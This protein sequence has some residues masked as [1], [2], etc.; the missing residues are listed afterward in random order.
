MK[1]TQNYTRE[2]ALS[3]EHHPTNT[4]PPAGSCTG[5]S[6]CLPPP[7]ACLTQPNTGELEKHKFV[8]PWG[9]QQHHSSA[10]FLKA[11]ARTSSREIWHQDPRAVTWNISWYF[12]KYAP[13]FNANTTSLSKPSGQ[14]SAF[15]FLFT[16][17]LWFA[18]SWTFCFWNETYTTLTWTITL[19]WII[20]IFHTASKRDVGKWV[21]IAYFLLNFFLFTWVSSLNIYRFQLRSINLLTKTVRTRFMKMPCPWHSLTQLKT[22]HWLFCFKIPPV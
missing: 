7:C 21:R 14:L 2:T 5:A 19:F 13:V 8:L 20:P 15:L 10:S 11:T 1:I 6:F 3:L 9:C 22:P 18:H 17:V 4:N 16:G 12:Y